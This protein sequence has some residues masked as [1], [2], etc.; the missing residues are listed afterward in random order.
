[1]ALAQKGAKQVVGIDIQDLFDN[2]KKEAIRLKLDQVTFLNC[3]SARL[4]DDAFDVVISHDSFEH[5]E[6]PGAVLM[7]MVRVTRPGGYVLI[8]FGPPWKNPW[9][10]HMSGTFRKDRPWI[11]LIVPEKAMMRVHSVY[12]NESE[13]RERYIELDGGLNKMTLE[14]FKR[15]I[16]DQPGV[17]LVDQQ[18]TPIVH[19]KIMTFPIVSEY[20]APS[21][22]A[23]L[24]KHDN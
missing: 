24:R 16:H 3:A 11:H 21:V 23:V 2:A 6:D 10:R 20:F 19:H 7:E 13:L 4:A 22:M 14:R 12:H 5:F 17:E 9:G 15:L 1:M 18:V 8:K